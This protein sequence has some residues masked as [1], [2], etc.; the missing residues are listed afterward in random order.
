MFRL[1]ILFLIA[2]FCAAFSASP[3][4][5]S[6][7]PNIID[8]V[9]QLSRDFATL[10]NENRALRREVEEIKARLASQTQTH[11]KE[12]LTDL[13]A[14]AMTPQSPTISYP[15]LP[16]SLLTN[17]TQIA[18]DEKRSKFTFF[19]GADILLP[20]ADR[21]DYLAVQ[22]AVEAD[23]DGM[24]RPPLMA[25]LHGGISYQSAEKSGEL[26][27]NL[28]HVSANWSETHTVSASNLLAWHSLGLNVGI[29]DQSGVFPQLDFGAT[30]QVDAGFS[31]SMVDLA[32]SLPV[33]DSA[34]TKLELNAGMRFAHMSS[35]LDAYETIEPPAG[36]R[37]T[38]PDLDV[39]RNKTGYWGAGTR[40]GLASNWRPMNGMIS[41]KSSLGAS[42]LYGRSNA[43]TGAVG[44]P[45]APA[46]PQTNWGE[47]EVS[48]WDMVT[49]LDGQFGVGLD[50][51]LARNAS[52][53]IE[54][55]AQ[56]E[57]WMGT[58]DFLRVAEAGF[59]SR[60]ELTDT[61]I[62]GAYLRSQLKFTW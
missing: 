19:A 46:G 60:S 33:L 53:S 61:S 56:A 40:L 58:R 23:F 22:P 59:G 14:T 8:V 42:F 12:Y 55:G 1:S 54:T 7:T 31:R 62:F 34:G 13:L 47:N 57:H 45:P 9:Q 6:T 20:S 43:C 48:S 17:D 30:Y 25:G 4:L 44:R 41:L 51:N 35:K 18:S 32:Y 21:F 37:P 2:F 38:G 10:K 50:W 29:A 36:P 52:L 5:A 28:K 39:S 24:A 15:G 16:A 11:N 3:L 27:V 26:S 49:V